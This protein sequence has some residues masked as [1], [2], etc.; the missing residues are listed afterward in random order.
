MKLHDKILFG[1]GLVPNTTFSRVE[2]IG[3]SSMT[4]HERVGPIHVE[5]KNHLRP[6]IEKIFV[7]FERLE[8]R[9]QIQAGSSVLGLYLIKKITT[10]LY[11]VSIS[12]AIAMAKGS[13]FSL[14]IPQVFG[15][16]QGLNNLP[17]GS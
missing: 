16:E 12:V 6:V 5:Q 7:P 10:E 15:T 14:R 4:L 3:F 8:S 13:H 9:L 17:A 2:I 1:L 11:G